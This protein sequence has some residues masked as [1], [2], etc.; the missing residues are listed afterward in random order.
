MPRGH[1]VNGRATGRARKRAHQ[2][3]AQK[4][5]EQYQEQL[6]REDEHLTDKE[7]AEVA[8]A[9]SLALRKEAMVAEIRRQR[10]TGQALDLQAALD[11]ARGSPLVLPAMIAQ[12][13]LSRV[14]MAEW[15]QNVKVLSDL[16]LHA[17]DLEIRMESADRAATQTHKMLELISA[18][19]TGTGSGSRY[20][21]SPLQPESTG[22]SREEKIALVRR[23]LQ[24]EGS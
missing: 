21:D 3:Q 11:A 18:R 5:E 1:Y 4:L 10:S 7:R 24:L 6:R 12:G 19:Q 16:G 22:L 8:Q 17:P 23:T 15:Y 9:R 20:V 2:E 13:D 14:A